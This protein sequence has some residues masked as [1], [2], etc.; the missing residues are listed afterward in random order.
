MASLRLAAAAEARESKLE[1]VIGR[2]Q[3]WMIAALLVCGCGCV[4]AL[5]VA[6]MTLVQLK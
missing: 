4:I 1:M 5:V 3:K 6:V 2:S